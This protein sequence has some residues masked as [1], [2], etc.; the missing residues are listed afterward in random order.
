MQVPIRFESHIMVFH[1]T[2]SEISA[3]TKLGYKKVVSVFK[4]TW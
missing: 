3:D 2:H 4:I 1:P